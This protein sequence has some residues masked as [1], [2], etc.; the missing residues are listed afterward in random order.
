MNQ[1]VLSAFKADI[2]AFALVF[3]QVADYFGK[4]MHHHYTV[5]DV[6]LQNLGHDGKDCVNYDLQDE[7][8][9]C[10][11][12]LSILATLATHYDSYMEKW[13]WDDANT[14]WDM[15]EQI[16]LED[17]FNPHVDPRM[18]LDDEDDDEDKPH[19][20]CF[21]CGHLYTHCTC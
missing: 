18:D 13:A 7:I 20:M 8:K 6:L 11:Q 14:A 17:N 4:D 21:V 3:R 9:K 5:I 12:I 19:N 2:R 15:A 16:E 10:E 1:A